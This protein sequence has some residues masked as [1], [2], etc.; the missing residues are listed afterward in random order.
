MSAHQP[1][2]SVNEGGLTDDEPPVT[3]LTVKEKQVLH[4][5]FHGKTSWEIALIQNCSVSTVNFHFTNIRRKFAVHSRMAAVYKA[6]EL[7]VIAVARRDGG[8]C[9]EH[10]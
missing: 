8:V 7:G 3:Q 5:C 4:W 10:D 1:L 6:I 9:D 2:N